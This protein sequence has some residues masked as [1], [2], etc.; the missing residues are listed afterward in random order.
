MFLSPIRL[1]S[2]G[3]YLSSKLTLFLTDIYFS[4]LGRKKEK[5][6]SSSSDHKRKRSPSNNYSGSIRDEA[7]TPQ[8]RNFAPV[9][10][11]CV[12]ELIVSKERFGGRDTLFCSQECISK[13]AED[14]RKV[15]F[16][17]LFFFII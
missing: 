6:H 15:C 5:H 1:A 2:D 12:C 8:K 16:F 3:R 10:Q 14:A 11:C 4:I 7:K 17:V 13:K 9:V